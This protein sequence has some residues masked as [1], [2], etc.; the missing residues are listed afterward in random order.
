MK[1]DYRDKIEKINSDRFLMLETIKEN[2]IKNKGALSKKID[3]VIIAL[4]LDE[5]CV[6]EYKAIIKVKQLILELVEEIYKA[7]S[8]EDIVKL[9]NKINYY[10]NKIKKEM[11]R[12]NVE[13]AK[14]ETLKNGV[15]DLR[16]NISMY[17][18]FLKRKENL[19]QIDNLMIDIGSLSDE[20]RIRVKKLINNEIRY[21]KKFFEIKNPSKD[22]KPQNIDVA[23]PDDDINGQVSKK[24]DD[25]ILKVIPTVVSNPSSALSK[26][27][28]SEEYLDERLEFY[29]SHYMFYDLFGYNNSILKNIVN[30]FRNIPRYRLNKKILKTAIMDYNIFQHT[31]ELEA[32]I[33]YSRKRNSVATALLAIFQSSYLSQRE[34][35][36]LFNHNNFKAWFTEFHMSQSNE[37]KNLVR[38]K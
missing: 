33:N 24:E 13:P 30:L 11:V 37:S 28:S 20:E 18:R 29:S 38:A 27:L 10:I 25:S 1:I 17:I 23:N 4:N 15:G 21:N 31:E 5:C 36:C 19:V 34:M 32:F 12:R 2:I 35:E 8:I 9:R 16:S 26:R 3:D 22:L 7:D 6:K 14:F